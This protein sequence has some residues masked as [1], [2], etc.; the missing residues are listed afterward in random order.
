MEKL[1]LELA[2]S[3]TGF[4]NAQVGLSERGTNKLCGCAFEHAS[5]R[6]EFE[7]EV[8]N[9]AETFED[10]A[11]G[12]QAQMKEEGGQKDDISAIAALLKTYKKGINLDK[13]RVLAREE[14]DDAKETA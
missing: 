14:W 8:I 13:L 11:R 2:S 6:E 10:F 9:Y 4:W 1:M 3:E 12:Q 5:T 7:N